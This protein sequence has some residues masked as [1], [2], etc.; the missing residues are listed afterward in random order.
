MCKL[1]YK[2][3]LNFPPKKKN[4]CSKND[5]YDKGYLNKVPI[6]KCV[7]Y[8]FD[9]GLNSAV[10]SLEEKENWATFSVYPLIILG[11]WNVLFFIS[12]LVSG[13]NKIMNFECRDC[14]VKFDPKPNTFSM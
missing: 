3:T 5:K 14:H 4:V 11:I 7:I 10:I 13:R 6:V 12:K 2:K 1:I 8:S 9:L